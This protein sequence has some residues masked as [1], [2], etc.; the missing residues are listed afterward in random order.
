MGKL[1]NSTWRMPGQEEPT[2]VV[3]AKEPTAELQPVEAVAVETQKL[4]ADPG[5]CLWRCSAL[6][7]EVIVVAR[8]ELVP[9]YPAGYPV[10]TDQELI[11][12][13]RE[14]VGVEV[15]RMAHEVKK[16]L[17]AKIEEVKHV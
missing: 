13:A 6:S 17:G 8:D 12:L 2:A 7:G 10:Y 15:I 14:G 4:L 5:W 9:G 3:V 1:P 11:E 16:T